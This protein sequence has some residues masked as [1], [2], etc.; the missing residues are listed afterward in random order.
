[1]EYFK[2]TK[3]CLCNGY[4]YDEIYE[5]KANHLV[6]EECGNSNNLIC[7]VRTSKNNHFSL[8]N[9][10]FKKL[11]KVENCS[12]NLDQKKESTLEHAMSDPNNCFDKISE[13]FKQSL[14]M[15]VTETVDC[16]GSTLNVWK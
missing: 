11:S 6:C 16:I 15:E 4:F 13:S 7:K 9:S 2:N 3:C 12:N 1:M 5:C 8:L 14:K 10:I